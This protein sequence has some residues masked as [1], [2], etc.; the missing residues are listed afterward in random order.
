[1]LGALYAEDIE[2]ERKRNY[3]D[4]SLTEGLLRAQ[5]DYFQ[6][7]REMFFSQYGGKLFVYEEEGRY[8]SGVRMEPFRDGVLLSCLVTSPEARRKG[9]AYNLLHFALEMINGTSVYAH[10]H[11]RNIASI[12]LHEKLG[13]SVLHDYA[14]MLDGSLRSDH[15]TYIKNG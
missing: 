5:E 1:M 14:Y 4:F 8:L 10:I 9:Y 12:R 13:F 3:K 15:F 6:Y 7:L 2:K 11:S